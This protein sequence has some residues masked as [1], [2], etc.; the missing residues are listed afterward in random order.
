MKFDELFFI[1]KYQ[2][3]NSELEI[4]TGK[5][6]FL[7][8]SSGQKLYRVQFTLVEIYRLFFQSVY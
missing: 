6:Q 3:T 5:F 1:H 8:E 4:T 7:V 2:L